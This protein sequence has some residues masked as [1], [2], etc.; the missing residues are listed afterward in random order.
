MV[1][2]RLLDYLEYQM[3]YAT[4]RYHK[5]IYYEVVEKEDSKITDFAYDELEHKFSQLA[6]K[7]GWPDAWVGCRDFRVGE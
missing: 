5:Y 7:Y 4:I 3:L 2:Q 6:I 1:D